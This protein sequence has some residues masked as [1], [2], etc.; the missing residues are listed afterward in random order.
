LT[1]KDGIKIAGY[2]FIGGNASV[3]GSFVQ[4]KVQYS[5]AA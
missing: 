1:S 4:K 3:N 2:N 5:Y